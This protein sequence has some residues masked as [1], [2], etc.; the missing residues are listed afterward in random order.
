MDVKTSVEKMVEKFKGP[1]SASAS[2]QQEAAGVAQLDELDALIAE[3]QGLKNQTLKA[4]VASTPDPA[5]VPTSVA[6]VGGLQEDMAKL[7]SDIAALGPNSSDIAFRNATTRLAQTLQNNPGIFHE[8]IRG[9]NPNV[10]GNLMDRMIGVDKASPNRFGE[11][12]E[13]MLTEHSDGFN[14]SMASL[15]QNEGNIYSIFV[16]KI[17]NCINGTTL[18]KAERNRI[19]ELMRQKSNDFY[20]DLH[21]SGAD[22]AS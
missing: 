9:V 4:T 18:D 15:K 21:I 1:A 11:R 2:T 3:A 13:Y 19:E 10:F 17:A 7:Q 14:K 8:L 12:L 20:A 5:S 6:K 16:K 22:S